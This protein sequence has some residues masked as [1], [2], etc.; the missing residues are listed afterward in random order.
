LSEEYDFVFDDL[1][2]SVLL[3]DSGDLI[4]TKLLGVRSSRFDPINNDLLTI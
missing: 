4:F 1:D 3:S 2:L